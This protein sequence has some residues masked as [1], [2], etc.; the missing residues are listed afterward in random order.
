MNVFPIGIDFGEVS[1]EARDQSFDDVT[2]A[3]RVISDKNLRVRVFY[4][5][6]GGFHR[7]Y[8]GLP[9]TGKPPDAL[10]ALDCGQR[11]RPLV[12]IEIVNYSFQIAIGTSNGVECVI[13]FHF[14]ELTQSLRTLNDCLHFVSLLASQAFISLLQ[15]TEE[16][17][18]TL[19]ELNL[20][21]FK[22]T[23]FKVRA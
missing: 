22:M 9:S 2:Q 16:F 1:V 13:I 20:I 18:L 6:Q 12:G 14:C 23:A 21:I 8:H 3:S 17:A 15:Q 11:N 7:Q 4:M 19:C 10:R 5:R